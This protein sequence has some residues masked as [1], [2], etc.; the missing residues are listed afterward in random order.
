MK[1]VIFTGGDMRMIYAAE[2]MSEQYSCSLSGFDSLDAKE[3]RGLPLSGSG[4]KYD[5]AVLPIFS[6]G[7]QLI[8]CP[9]ANKA[10]DINILPMLLDRGGI[11]FA[12]KAFPE[13]R[14]L[15]DEHG[16]T[17][18]DYLARE[19][20]AVKNAVL[21]AEGAVGTA[22]R[23]TPFSI[24]GSDILILGFGRIGKLC[25]VYFSALGGHVTAAARKKSDLAW[26]NAYGFTAADF[27][28]ENGIREALANAD[29]IINTAPA[30]ILT[31]ERAS[32]VRKDALLIELAS[33]PCTEEG[34]GIRTVSAGGLPGKTAPV[35]AGHIIA[36]TIGNI[37][38][39]RSME[40][41]GA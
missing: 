38:T 15:C 17:L 41:G 3:R 19:E 32:A 34:S 22:I 10:Y 33:V 20:L 40:N 31:G 4:E 23:E 2:R 12:G 29:I 36:D 35:S 14:E 9:F 7:S 1:K 18:Y 13:L 21:T 30:R 27:S 24:H 6:G 16:L 39:E 37:L 26:I 5:A 8:R 28:D 11:V 25:A